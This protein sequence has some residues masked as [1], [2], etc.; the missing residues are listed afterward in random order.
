MVPWNAE[1]PHLSGVPRPFGDGTDPGNKMVIRNWNP[2]EDIAIPAEQFC[3]NCRRRE[4]VDGSDHYECLGHELV[5][6]REAVDAD[7]RLV[8]RDE[9]TDDR[10]VPSFRGRTAT[11]RSR[12]RK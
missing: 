9:R 10:I 5:S 7:D 2:V 6:S 1:R 8:V 3:W 12:Q 4:Y 11:R